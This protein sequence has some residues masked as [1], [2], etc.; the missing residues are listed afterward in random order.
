MTISKLLNKKSRF[1]KKSPILIIDSSI[2]IYQALYSTGYLSYNGK[3]VGIIYGFLK[4]ILSIAKRFKTNKFIFC[5]D[6]ASSHRKKIYS[7]Y[8]KNRSKKEKTLEEKAA[9]KSLIIQ[10]EELRKQILPSLG[11]KNNF[12]QEGYEGDDILAYWAL[13]L[14]GN[15]IITTDADLYQCLNNCDIWNPRTKKIFTGQHLLK[16]FGV[17]PDQWP[18]AKAIGGCNGDSVEGIRGI[19]DSK[20]TNSKALKYLQKKLSKGAILDK[21]ESKEGQN[22]IKRNLPLV[23]LPYNNKQHPITRMIIKRNKFN[24]EKFLRTFDSLHF[25]SFLEHKNFAEWKEIFL[26]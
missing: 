24:R 14:K 2:L 16:E 13:K 5:W 17:T 6:S 15:I 18:L 11:F 21:I 26:E 9:L 23:S 3:P 22:I 19:S 8:K 1:K 25:K 10:K 20:N 12:I 4:N 7:D